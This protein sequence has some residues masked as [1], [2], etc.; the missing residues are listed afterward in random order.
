MLSGKWQALSPRCPGQGLNSLTCCYFNCFQTCLSCLGYG[1]RC[2]R[3]A[4][5][6]AGAVPA[7]PRIWQVLSPH[8]PRYGRRCPVLSGIWQALCPRC[9]GY[10]RRCPC[11]VRG[12]AGA[13]PALS[14][15]W[16]ALSLRCPG[17]GLNSLTCC[18]FNC[19]QTCLSLSPACL[20][21]N[22]LMA[23]NEKETV[24]NS[25]HDTTVHICNFNWI[26]RFL[27]SSF[28]VNF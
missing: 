17:Q 16:Q 14:G 10:G 27:E 21:A 25:Y 1:R 26:I 13:V 18:Y 28:N 7:L 23:L 15:I 20:S 12:M 8:C 6:M 3:I 5:D 22:F 9:L 2:S 24:G 4:Q 11:V 19:L